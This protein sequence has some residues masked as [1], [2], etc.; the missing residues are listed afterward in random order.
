MTV[1]A[2]VRAVAPRYAVAVPGVECGSPLNVELCVL[3]RPVFKP[4]VFSIRILADVAPGELPMPLTQPRGRTVDI[5]WRCTCGAKRLPS[6]WFRVHIFPQARPELAQRG[7][8]YA[9]AVL[10][11]K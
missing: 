8:L 4:R 5:R 3:S 6:V 7:V 1:I 9:L 11:Y 2:F 10:A